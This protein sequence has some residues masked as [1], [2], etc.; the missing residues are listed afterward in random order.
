M[1]R[2][3]HGKDTRKLKDA[4]EKTIIFVEQYPQGYL[5]SCIKNLP[6]KVV[7]EE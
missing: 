3:V 6:E 2:A 4:A 7:N 1:I 5:L